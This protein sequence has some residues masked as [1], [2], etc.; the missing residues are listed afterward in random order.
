MLNFKVGNAGI[1]RHFSRGQCGGEFFL[2]CCGQFEQPRDWEPTALWQE[3][4]RDF[5][6]R[7]FCLAKSEECEEVAIIELPEQ[8]IGKQGTLTRE[9]RCNRKHMFI[10]CHI[11]IMLDLPQVLVRSEWESQRSEF[12]QQCVDIWGLQELIHHSRR[13]NSCLKTQ[14]QL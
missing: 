11:Q 2:T 7:Y 1:E 12:L 6:L 10:I 8:E 3:V 13:Q 5:I 4:F 14:T 9:Q